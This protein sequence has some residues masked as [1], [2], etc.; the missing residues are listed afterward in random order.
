MKTNAHPYIG[1]A[2]A[3]ARFQLSAAGLILATCLLPEPAAAQEL[4]PVTG[5]MIV[6]PG[7]GNQPATELGYVQFKVDGPEEAWGINC[8]AIADFAVTDESFFAGVAPDS[9]QMALAP[10]EVSLGDL[11][12][13]IYTEPGAFHEVMVSARPTDPYLLQLALGQNPTVQ[14]AYG[15]LLYRSALAG[16]SVSQYFGHFPWRH[17]KADPTASVP[18]FSLDS[19]CQEA[20]WRRLKNHPAMQNISQQQ[21]FSGGM[22]FDARMAGGRLSIT[23]VGL[24]QPALTAG[25]VPTGPGPTG[26]V[27]ASLKGYPTSLPKVTVSPPMVLTF[28]GSPM[29]QRP[30]FHAT[31]AGGIAMIYTVHPG[32]NL[33]LSASGYIPGMQVG[34]GHNTTQERLYLPVQWGDFGVMK[35]VLPSTMTLGQWSVG[36][37]RYPVPGQPGSYYPWAP[38][39]LA[40]RAQVLVQ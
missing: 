16:G 19:I 17:W 30:W 11:M 13:S 8:I 25:E 21:F 3:T 20:A 34:I 35:I 32:G 14:F 6:E 10:A 26:D 7:S 31:W 36:A 12:G 15:D 39:P 4:P 27:P 18:T 22:W 9:W 24:R 38:I 29:T 28:S 40:E 23:Y 5:S 33:L 37:F 2:I 1:G